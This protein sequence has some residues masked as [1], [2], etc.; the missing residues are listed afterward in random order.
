MPPDGPLSGLN[1]LVLGGVGPAQ[2]CAMMLA[3]HGA[4]VVV[5]Q[6]PTEVLVPD[7]SVG[8]DGVDVLGRGCER[9]VLDL[10]DPSD[11]QTAL[12]LARLADVVVEGFRPGVVERLGIGPSDCCPGNPG[13]V[14]ARVTGYGQDGP[15]SG[16]AGHDI[17]YLAATGVLHAIGRHGGPP[18]V[19]LNLLADYG[20]GGMLLAFGVCAALW[21]RERSGLGQVVDAAMVDGVALLMASVFEKMSNAQWT[22]ERGVNTLDTGQPNYD[23]YETSD[24]RWMAVGAR[25]PVFH[26]R[27]LDALG[28][29]D[30]PVDVPPGEVEQRR[31]VIA[32]RFSQ[33]TQDEWTAT[34]TAT[35]ACVTPVLSLTDASHSPHLTERGTYGGQP[36]A[37][38]PGA[39]PRFSRTPGGVGA[40]AGT[41]QPV[42][43]RWQAKA[44]RPAT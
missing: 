27:M 21:E 16:Q 14:Y 24:R 9:V 32:D 4:D 38:Q 41:G 29:A 15:L 8:P 11:L 6:R 5:V 31:S 26:R 39:A 13:L 3:D 19:P 18:Q 17:N 35:D 25:E 33:R 30:L 2:F 23:V 42:L 10:K 34:F 40:P 22:D 12:V 20:G 36:G 1:V 7:R 28:L 44:Q 37:V 43:S